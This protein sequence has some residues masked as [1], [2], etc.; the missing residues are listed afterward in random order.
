MRKFKVEVEEY[1]SK[2]IEVEAKTRE[3]ALMIVKKM[4]EK[5]KVILDNR[6]FVDKNFKVINDE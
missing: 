4:Y 3:E 1:L 2:T 5:E 6:D